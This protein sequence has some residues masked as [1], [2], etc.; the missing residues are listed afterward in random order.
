MYQKNPAVVEVRLERDHTFGLLAV[1]TFVACEARGKDSSKVKGKW[2]Y[3]FCIST[4]GISMSDRRPV[5]PGQSAYWCA[6]GL[7]RST[8]AACSNQGSRIARIAGEAWD[9]QLWC[10]EGAQPSGCQARSTC[11]MKGRA[12]LGGGSRKRGGRT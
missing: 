11:G 5:A 1:L 3:V 12:W 6:C 8:N 4:A 9:V 10:G 7:K 2:D